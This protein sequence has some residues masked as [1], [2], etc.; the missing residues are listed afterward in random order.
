MGAGVQEVGSPRGDPGSQTH[1]HGQE[2]TERTA[3]VRRRPVHYQ[4]GQCALVGGELVAG[5]V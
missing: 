3:P 4:C 5:H 1:G 2:K